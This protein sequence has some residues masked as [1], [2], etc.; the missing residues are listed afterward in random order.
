MND[1]IS[2]LD[3]VRRAVRAGTLPTG[4]GHV[5]ELRRTYPAPPDDVWDACTDPACIARWFLPITGELRLGGRYQLE[6]NAGGEITGCDPPRRLDVTWEFGGDV[7]LV[8]VELTPAGDGATELRLEHTVPDNDHWATYGPGATGVG[9]DLALLGLGAY[10]RTGEGPAD[11]AAL[12]ASPEA[13][14]FMRRSAE[15]WGEAHAASGVP[16]ELARETAARTSAAY[17]PEPEA[18]RS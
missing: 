17:T 13:R 1:L 4:D 2:E 14:T 7:S 10:L 12:I 15:A 5:V 6:R 3:E 18:A 11:P 16:R 9:W 8:A